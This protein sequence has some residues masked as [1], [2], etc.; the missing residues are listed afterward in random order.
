M[1]ISELLARFGLDPAILAAGTAGGLLRGLS[2][3]RFRFREVVLSPICGALAAGYMTTPIMHIV[4]HYEWPPVPM[5]PSADYAAAFV[6]GTM[7]M[8]FSDLVF[9]VVWRWM[10]GKMPES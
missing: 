5:E 2:R 7:A 4:R 1:N 8:W 3:H 9:E 10:K 6:I